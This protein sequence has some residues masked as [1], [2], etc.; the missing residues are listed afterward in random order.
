M[1][2]LR[3][4]RRVLSAFALHALSVTMILSGEPPAAPLPRADTVAEPWS[5]SVAIGLGPLSLGAGS[6][7]SVFRLIEGPASPATLHEGQWEVGFHT[8][9]ANYFSSDGDAYLLDYETLRLRVGAAYGVSRRTEIGIAASASYQGA[10]ILDGFIEGFERAVGAV[11]HERLAAPRDRFLIRVRD[12]DGSLHESSGGDAGWLGDNTTFT[13]KH[14]ILEGSGSTPA[15]AATVTVKLPGRAGRTGRP[16]GGVDV[17]GGLGVAQRLG[18]FNLYGGV[19]A[20][21]FGSSDADGGALRS[22]QGSLLLAGEYRATARTSLVAQAIVSSPVTRGIGDFSDRTR[23][24]AIGCKHLVAPDLLLEMSVAENLLV[25]GN[26]ADVA[27][28]AG[29]TW[30]STTASP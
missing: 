22:S 23:E 20:V 17:G 2:A 12:P 29:L 21:Y 18:R 1:G 16:E 30:R 24:V 11:N 19:S 14:A 9:W 28:H 13:L 27:F 6:P 7:M 8:E 4:L 10:G 25:F 3:L 15:L 5:A 26:S